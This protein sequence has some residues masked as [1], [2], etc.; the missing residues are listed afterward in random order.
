M[1][2]KGR[3]LGRGERSAKPEVSQTER[4]LE[5]VHATLSRAGFLIVVMLVKRRF[6]VAHSEAAV[7]MMERSASELKDL[8]SKRQGS[9]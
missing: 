1:P 3:L 8:I 5:S 9:S 6:S 7:E 2:V 4:V